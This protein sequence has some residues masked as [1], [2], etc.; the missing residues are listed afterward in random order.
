[1]STKTPVEA[2]DEFTGLSV[3]S[4]A[5]GCSVAGC[6]ISGDICVHPYKGGL[7]SAHMMKPPVL[8]KFA[9]AKRQLFLQKA[10]K[11]ADS[12]EKTQ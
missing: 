7:Q 10:G 4:C 2:P 6:V 12:M 5:D 8:K 11:L 9:A 3:D 1:M